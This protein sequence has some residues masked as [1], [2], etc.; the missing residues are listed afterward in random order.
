MAIVWGSWKNTGS[1]GM[2]IGYD[3]SRTSVSSSSSSVLFT[4][5]IY[6]QN[7]YP[8]SDDQHIDFGSY[9]GSRHNFR[10]SSSGGAVL[11]VTRSYRYTYSDYGKSRTLTSSATVG[12]VWSGLTPTVS[13]RL[14]V[15]ARPYASPRTPTNFRIDASTDT[16]ATLRWS[17]NTTSQRPYT[18]KRIERRYWLGST[19]SGWVF[20][21]TVSSGST[22]YV[23]RSL[24]ADQRYQFRIRSNNKAGSSGWGY[25]SSNGTDAFT[26]P[27]DPTN[28]RAAVESTGDSI[29]VTWTRNN[30]VTSAAVSF[31]VQRQTSA[32]GA[33]STRASGLAGD[34]T[35]WIDNTPNAGYNRYRVRVVIVS[36]L[37]NTQSGYAYTASITT[38]VP[39][40]AP[41]GLQIRP[42]VPDFGRDVTLY[43][44]HRHGGD[45]ADQTYYQIAY[46]F[47][48]ADPWEY[49]D[50]IASDISQH[51]FEPDTLPNGVDIEFRVRTRGN[52]QEGFGLYSESLFA[53]G[54]TSP[55]VTL[56]EDAPAVT[57]TNIP[58]DVAWIY[59]QDEGLDQLR[60]EVEVWTV[61]DEDDGLG[62][63]VLREI[64]S[65]G[66]TVATIDR[67][68]DDGAAYV[69]R[70]R[71]TSTREQQSPWDSR[72]FYIDMLAPAAATLT[73]QYDDDTGVMVLSVE[74]HE[75]RHGVE[76]GRNLAIDPVFENGGQRIASSTFDITT[77]ERPDGGK[78]LHMRA[79]RDLGTYSLVTFEIRP[80]GQVA[81]GQF[82]AFR[83]DGLRYLGFDGA[84]RWRI[85]TLTNGSWY[86]PNMS[87]ADPGE[88]VSGVYQIPPDSTGDYVRLVAY[89]R[90][91]ANYST[92][93]S[94]GQTA[95]LDAWTA[96]IAPTEAEATAIVGHHFDGSMSPTATHAFRWAGEPHN[97]PSIRFA[98]VDATDDPD[99]ILFEAA[100]DTFS[101]QRRVNSGQWVTIIRD[102]SATPVIDDETDPDGR[103][104]VSLMDL[105]PAINGR[106]EYRLH[107]Q[108]VAPSVADT[109]PVTVALRPDDNRGWTFL[110]YGP[111][112]GNVLR[113]GNNVSVDEALD[114]DG[115]DKNLAGRARPVSLFGEHERRTLSIS[116]QLYH[117]EL[118]VAPS[119]QSPLDSPPEDWRR[120]IR[121]AN[122][123]CLRTPAGHRIFGRMHGLRLPTSNLNVTGV[124]FSVT[125]NDF[126]EEEST[127][128]GVEVSQ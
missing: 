43:W 13:I 80:G 95:T 23:Y 54:Y 117:D 114:K 102:I 78:T 123:V 47:D 51:A 46:R 128:A 121:E 82:V 69:V 55:T 76:D 35:S 86:Y 15:P 108:S 10:N 39:P 52:T 74:P 125:E 96:T 25:S 97:S 98:L 19:W 111:D 45:G 36:A 73:P 124:S 3:V 85:G 67:V 89:F 94:E 61:N 77:V 6:T 37:N 105:L 26:K 113:V 81:P 9:L 72:T 71:A 88:S 33:W 18:S 92:L 70:V 63:R 109:D 112:M 65:N 57:V 119:S 91:G 7:K 59:N 116:G 4:V 40:I 5:K 118:H 41:A 87:D 31:E 75:P 27:R 11:R 28:A 44:E 58:F 29:R 60:A 2:R 100:L 56:D 34:A 14:S 22:S 8:F 64:V 42:R 48:P 93:L 99:A 32:S 53:T 24:S 30:R 17:N 115:E 101:I 50:E 103:F 62:A 79:N 120:A 66:D 38:I 110:N 68:L 20:T 107:L 84:V 104:I 106:N 83:L 127:G 1:N 122:T 126:R 16:T 49:S 21:A 90:T 12:G